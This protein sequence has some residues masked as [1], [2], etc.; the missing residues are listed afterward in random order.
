MEF[1]STWRQAAS[2]AFLVSSDAT[3]RHTDLEEAIWVVNHAVL[4]LMFDYF[5][6]KASGLRTSRQ[7]KGKRQW[8]TDL[9][10]VP[11]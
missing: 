8:S 7:T 3:V 9:S 10:A 5:F 4:F 11:I 2:K 6:G 1:L